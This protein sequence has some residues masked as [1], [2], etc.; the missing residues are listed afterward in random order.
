M[1]NKTI[2]WMGVIYIVSGGMACFTAFPAFYTLVFYLPMSL[3][4]IH[5]F[6]SGK[7]W[8]VPAFVFILVLY[9]FY[10]AFMVLAF[11]SILFIIESV[12]KT[13]FRF[14]RFLV[15]GMA[16]LGLILLGVALSGVYLLPTV[17]F[18]LEDTYRG[19]G[20]F[21]A[22]VVEIGSWELELFQPEIYIRMLAKTFTEQRAA[23]FVGFLDQYMYEHVSL[24]ITVIGLAFMSYVFFMRD[25][26]SWIYKV[27]LIL[28][29]IT[30][31]F[32]FFSYVF[33]GTEYIVD[34]PYTRW[35]DM[36]PLLEIVILAHVY[37]THGW[38]GVKM[39][40]LTIPVVIMLATIGYLIYYYIPQLIA[41]KERIDSGSTFRVRGLEALT[42]EA[43]FLGIAAVYLILLLVFGWIKKM[44]WIKWVFLVEFIAGIGYIYIVSYALVDRITFF[45]DMESI[46]DFLNENIEQ[47]E[48]YRVYV[49][50]ENFNVQDQN[51]NRMTTFWTNTKVLFHSWGDS[52]TDK[53]SEILFD[54]TEYQDKQAT[55]FYNMY[56]EHVLG[57]KYLLVNA[58][59]EYNLPEKYFSLVASEGIYELY[60]FLDY[61][62]FQVYE[63]YTTYSAFDGEVDDDIEE[64]LGQMKLLNTILLE[65][66]P[67]EETIQ[68][69]LE[70]ND[71]FEDSL[72]VSNTVKLAKTIKQ[73]PTEVQMTDPVTGELKWYYCFDAAEM[74][75]D[76][77]SGDVRFKFDVYGD[78]DYTDKSVFWVNSNGETKT[79]A[80]KEDDPNAFYRATNVN[81]QGEITKST[82]FIKCGQFFYEPVRFYFEKVDNF[83]P[84][85]LNIWYRLERAIDGNSYLVLNLPD[86]MPDSGM[87][88]MTFSKE[89]EKAFV[90]DDLGNKTHFIGNLCYFTSKPERVFIYKTG[91]MYTDDPFGYSAMICTDDMVFYD[92]NVD[93]D[94]AIDETMT[95]EHGRIDLSYT[96]TSDSEYDQI[97]MIPVTYSEEWVITSEIP[98]QTLPVTGGFLGVVIPKEI[99]EV[100]I[101]MEFI[102]KGL[103]TGGWITLGSGAVY[104]GIYLV[105]HFIK[106]KKKRQV[107]PLVSGE[108]IPS[109]PEVTD[110]EE[111]DSHRTVL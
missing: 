101:T 56:L 47:D 30:M 63:A 104:A 75:I 73:T 32:P 93:S 78:F 57:Y 36:L 23:G 95:I 51:F 54:K 38:D 42:A 89:F 107:H 4:I 90:E 45:D 35:I 64:Y 3:V 111:T 40:W 49:D 50:V 68:A 110:H 76:F 41:I 106:A 88:L 9:N 103:K 28:I 98:F 37:D 43:V 22:W 77:F 84:D 2:F 14:G 13:P 48:F 69:F 24:Y 80:S 87:V 92:E 96:R 58:D 26:I 25:K 83:T 85:T 94:L 100:D 60:E 18:I 99:T 5:W 71:A 6:H 79:P 27:V 39:K 31:F 33:S 8:V 74:E 59:N 10:C 82:T 15:D 97:I 62:P 17:Q 29:P 7:S 91:A 12:K 55:A 67:G 65:E 102:P 20:N 1:K 105:L 46:N 72:E 34:L 109:H 19:T 16:F 81:A 86:D 52:E 44:K 61:E 53:I 66:A 70:A 108:S 11:M 21:D